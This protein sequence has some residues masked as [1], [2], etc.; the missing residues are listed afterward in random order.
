MIQMPASAVV[1]EPGNQS[2]DETQLVPGRDFVRRSL[3]HN[4]LIAQTIY[5]NKFLLPRPPE[6][7]AFSLVP[8]DQQVTVVWAPSASD[9]N[10]V[11]GTAGTG[12]DPYYIIASDPK[13]PLYNANYRRCDV[14]GYRIYRYRIAMLRVLARRA[15]LAAA[16][17][18]NPREMA[19]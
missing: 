10:C 1:G 6:P 7:P 4:A 11:E 19:A 14:E 3:V 12:G 16:D 5:N 9:Q 8:G 18:R 17:R 13:S 2:I 15:V